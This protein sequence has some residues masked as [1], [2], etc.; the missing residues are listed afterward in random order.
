MKQNNLKELHRYANTILKST[1]SILKGEVKFHEK[2][3][4][5]HTEVITEWNKKYIMIKL[6]SRKSDLASNFVSCY[7]KPAYFFTFLTRS[8]TFNFYGKKSQYSDVLLS[9]STTQY[10]MESRHPRL[11]L[12]GKCLVF[13]G[14]VRRNDTESLSN[15][16]ILLKKLRAE[17]DKLSNMQLPQ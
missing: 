5:W 9:S 12:E 2:E 7:L 1:S 17:I 10:L 3:D 11:G 13:N 14:G 8:D 4:Y 16:F 6:K 15:V